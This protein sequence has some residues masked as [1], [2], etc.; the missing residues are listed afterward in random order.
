MERKNLNNHALAKVH[1]EKQKA[2]KTIR[3]SQMFFEI[4]SWM[5]SLHEIKKNFQK[6]ERL[7][8]LVSLYSSINGV[9][10]E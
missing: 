5:Q 4:S 1:S 9:E 10:K 6:G 2:T 3:S 7:H 8:I